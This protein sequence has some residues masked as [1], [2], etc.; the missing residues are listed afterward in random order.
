MK[1]QSLF[2]L[3]FA[4]LALVNFY[5]QTNWVSLNRNYIVDLKKPFSEEAQQFDAEGKSVSS[6]MSTAS[7]FITA[8][9]TPKFSWSVGLAYKDIHFRVKDRIKNWKY[10]VGY[11]NNLIIDTLHYT[12]QD[13]ADFVA[14]SKSYGFLNQFSYTLFSKE[15][16][17]NYIGLDIELYCWEN[18][19]SRYESDD[20]DPTINMGFML[21]EEDRPS[22]NAPPLKHFFSSSASAAV[23]YKFLYTP[24]NYFSIG[25]KILYGANLQSDWDEFKKYSW[26]GFGIE[27]GFGPRKAWSKKSE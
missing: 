8:I 13:P 17:K 16:I 18:Y 24:T 26:L 2:L 27:L 6:S 3:F 4:S 14:E 21:Q 22:T 12:F 1:K 11:D 15:K 7:F 9:K 20:F 19:E 10:I 5:A 25:A 23:F